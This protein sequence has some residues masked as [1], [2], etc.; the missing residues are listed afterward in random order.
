MSYEV[1]PLEIIRK[2]KEGQN[3]QQLL[4]SILEDEMGSTPQGA[5][6]LELAKM[7]KGPEIERF[8]R[9]VCAERGLDFDKEFTAFKQQFGL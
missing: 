2:I 6:L 8:A 1:N 9:N 5:N 7:G 4:I 3:P